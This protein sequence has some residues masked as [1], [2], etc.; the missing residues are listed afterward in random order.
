MIDFKKT[1]SALLLDFEF[2]NRMVRAVPEYFVTAFYLVI[3]VARQS[4]QFYFVN[5]AQAS[6]FKMS[7]NSIRSNLIEYRFSIIIYY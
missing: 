6:P 2:A 3:I 7:V 1:T 4:S 5:K